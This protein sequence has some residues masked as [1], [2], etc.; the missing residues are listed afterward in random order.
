MITYIPT[1]DRGNPFTVSVHCWEMPRFSPALGV[2]YGQKAVDNAAWGVRVIIDGICVASDTFGTSVTFPQLI[3][4][5]D[6]ADGHGKKRPLLFPPFHRT[7]LSRRDWDISDDLGRIKICISEGY[8]VKEADGQSFVPIKEVVCFTFHPAPLERLERCNIA[9]PNPAMWYYPWRSG[10]TELPRQGQTT[11]IP[12][13]TQYQSHA[14]HNLKTPPKRMSLDSGYYTGSRYTGSSMP[15]PPRPTPMAI[16]NSLIHPFPDICST[17]SRSTS[18]QSITQQ[19]SASF[20][21]HN[22]Q[23]RV[24]RVR[25]PTDQIQEIVSALQATSQGFEAADKAPP[26]RM[27]VSHHQRMSTD[28]SMHDVDHSDTL[29]PLSDPGEQTE[30]DG[31]PS[32]T[33]KKR[34]RSALADKD[35]NV[36]GEEPKRKISKSGPVLRSAS[37]NA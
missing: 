31:V 11:V 12:Q 8:L 5:S 37:K 24:P 17:D 1:L 18:G 14:P 29:R 9:W 7:V 32:I 23:S 34:S 13:Q 21:G 15:P 16:T 4:A 2:F 27:T 36:R 6:F 20:P 26:A 19:L 10:M 30:R 25:L 22:E 33:V 35:P 3:T 28:M